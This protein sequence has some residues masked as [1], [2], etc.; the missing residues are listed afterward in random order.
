MAGRALPADRE[1]VLLGPAHVHDLRPRHRRP[2]IRQGERDGFE[3]WPLPIDALIFYVLKL[4][5]SIT[6][7]ADEQWML[8]WSV[9]ILI[10]IIRV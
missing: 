2:D 4:L 6:E 7:Q 8:A 9:S 10:S 3:L 5:E 1:P